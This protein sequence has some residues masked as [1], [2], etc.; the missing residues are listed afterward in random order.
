MIVVGTAG[1]VDHGKSALVR[2]LTGTDPDRLAEEKARG[3]TID[4]GFAWRPLP[5]GAQ[6]SLVDVPG[7]E[8]FIRNMLAGAGGIDAALLVVAAD[9]G[10]MP[11]TREHLAILDLLGVA[12]GVIALSKADLV[13]ADWL[14]MVAEE[15]RELVAGTGLAAAPIIPVSA[16]TGQGLEALLAA[17][18]DLAGRLPPAPDLGR[19]RM[20][21]DRA[22]SVAGFGTV[23]TGTLREGR[24]RPGDTLEILPA[25]WRSRARG[26]Q[27]Q[28]RPVAELAPGARA[29]V[30]LVGL[31]A[32]AIERGMVLAAP[33]GFRPSRL[34]DVRLR[35]L[36]DAPGALGHDAPVH[37]FQG[38]AEIPGRLRLI[39]QR[40]I[41]PGGSGPAQIRLARPAVL[42]AGDRFVLRQPSPARTIGGGTVLDP[43][44]PARHRRF[45]PQVL[46]RF[47]A[48]AG[49]DPALRAWHMLAAR[50]PC[51]AEDL[52]PAETGLEPGLRD[53]ALAALA[54]AGRAHRLGALWIT[55]AGWRAL[56][57]R[58]EAALTRHHRRYPLRPGVP[59][60]ELRER[61][62]IE[63]EAFAALLVRGREEGWLARTGDNLHRPEHQIRLAPADRAA[64]DALLARFRAD[65][66][67]GPSRKEAEQALGAAVLG[68]LL[69]QGE[70]VAAGDEVLF[71]AP[72][73]AALR[74]GI[75]AQLA[76]EGQV[77]VA[78]VR[79]RFATSRKYALAILEHLDRL[80][81][82][83][84]LGDAHVPAG[85]VAAHPD[86]LQVGA[87][88][89]PAG[90]QGMAGAGTGRGEA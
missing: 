59:P 13:D 82:T 72:A 25:G 30:N 66:Y 87:T 53:A 79:D 47:E 49:G 88:G 90:W 3:L 10:P 51:R 1:H 40:A 24:L 45:K 32:G 39:G 76:A 42:A 64:A 37:L 86:P 36:A 68:A 28:G 15:L 22:F 70:L 48:L 34:V 81:L 57:G 83:R 55:D 80:R 75:L 38:A 63:G 11:Q 17:L 69:A 7:H 78:D 9:E 6:L 44:P 77:T 5:S 23:V 26:L 73:Y 33:G 29:A 35:L 65:P 74:A 31:E 14:A 89:E 52:R 19:P 21:I 20:S 12:P 61:L 27:T 56:R 67:R 54:E 2:A 62:G 71:D 50:E 41:E 18:D 8:G 16:T 84:R 58:A 60:E 85:P 46:A 43:Q 4:L